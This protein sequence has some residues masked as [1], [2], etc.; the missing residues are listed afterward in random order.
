MTTTDW[1]VQYVTEQAAF[2]AGGYTE[3]AARRLVAALGR[4][5]P[6]VQ[7][8]TPAAVMCRTVGDW[9]PAEQQEAS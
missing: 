9:E 4:E 5:K 8:P 2:V 3:A 6:S 7:R 1:G